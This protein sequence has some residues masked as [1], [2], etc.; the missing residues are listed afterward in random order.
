MDIENYIWPG[1][2]NATRGTYT[3]RVDYY[4]HCSASGPVPYEV[5]VRANG[6]TRYYCGT[7]QPSDSDSGGKGSGRTITDV[8]IQ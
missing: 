4:N 2:V 5:E 1:H 3:V 7:F 8:V 6:A